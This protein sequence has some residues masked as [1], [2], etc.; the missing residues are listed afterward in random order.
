VKADRRLAVHSARGFGLLISE[1]QISSEMEQVEVAVDRQTG[2]G[3]GGV[4]FKFNEDQLMF[5][6]TT[7][8]NGR[9]QIH[10]IKSDQIPHLRTALGA[11]RSNHKVPWLIKSAEGSR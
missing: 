10:A 3:G 2:G 1:E 8:M 7:L 5:C 9:R 4:Y 11:Y 6:A